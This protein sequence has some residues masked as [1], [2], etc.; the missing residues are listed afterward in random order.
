MRNAK[1]G[2]KDAE[3]MQKRCGRDAEKMRKRCKMRTKLEKSVS[4]TSTQF[5]SPFTT[6]YN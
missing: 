3:E 4:T 6:P 1:R 5:L 2:R